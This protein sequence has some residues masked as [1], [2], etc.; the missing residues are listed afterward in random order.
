MSS[1]LTFDGLPDI[2]GA[3]RNSS[4][5]GKGTFG[6]VFMARD[7]LK[8]RDVVVKEVVINDENKEFSMKEVG[9]MTQLQKLKHLNIVQLLDVYKSS[10]MFNDQP[11]TRL[12]MV[13]E[14]YPHVLGS[15]LKDPEANF[16]LG[17]IKGIAKQLLSAVKVMH[18]HNIFHRDLK[19]DNIFISHN[20]ILKV[21]D[22]GL[23]DFFEKKTDGRYGVYSR[24]VITMWYRPPELL[25]GEN[26]YGPEVDLWSTGCILAELFTSHPLLRGSDEY[27]QLLYI[28]V[29]CGDL[30]PS[31]WPGVDFLQFYNRFSR[32]LLKC[33][34][35]KRSIKERLNRA[36]ADEAGKDLISR[37]LVPNP[38]ERFTAKQAL[39]H[40][41]FTTAPFPNDVIIVR[42][43]KSDQS[44]CHDGNAPKRR[45]I[46]GNNSVSNAST[47]VQ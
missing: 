31:I 47:R 36:I 45:K 33:N 5:L 11:Q 20:G 21:G 25:F 4:I 7:T 3:Y 17:N 34:L 19:P 46:E 2:T 40:A 35:G 14:Y 6:E 18:D 32:F 9:V 27:T 44:Y 26:S 12:H 13:M 39:E 28:S 16:E 1:L 43:M 42:K 8:G 15:M 24:N 41:F 23:S 10:G 30:E 22:F 37:L 29:L 38:R